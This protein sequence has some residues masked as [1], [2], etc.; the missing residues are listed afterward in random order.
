MLQVSLEPVKRSSWRF[1]A[2][3]TRARTVAEN[4][5]YSILASRLAP[6][7]RPCR[8]LVLLELLLAPLVAQLVEADVV[9]GDRPLAGVKPYLTFGPRDCS[10]L[11]SA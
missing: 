4:A 10:R 8:G 1:L 3:W 2:L 6:E 11:W 5:S 7:H 9:L